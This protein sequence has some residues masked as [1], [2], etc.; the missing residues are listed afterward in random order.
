[1]ET[2][3]LG[4]GCFWCVE[5]IFRTLTGVI[6]VEVGYAGGHVSS[7]SYEHVCS[8]KTGHAEVVKVTFDPSIILLE[9]VLDVFFK[10]HDP[11]TV[12]RQ[13]NDIGN[14]YRSVV[15]FHL[16]SQEDVILKSIFKW[17]GDKMFNGKI[18]TEVTLVKN[19]HP[20]E[21]YHQM[22][23]DKNKDAPY[24]RAVILPKLIKIKK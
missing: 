8:G 18:E 6:D 1:M 2:I 19:Y 4:A 17:N 10:S 23:Y 13:G 11:T 22:Y 5:A 21:E 24:C 12:D 7:P 20:A 9:G 14:Q 15:F 16:D 3:T